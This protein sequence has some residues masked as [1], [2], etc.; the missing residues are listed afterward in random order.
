M[1]GKEMTNHKEQGGVHKE[2]AANNPLAHRVHVEQGWYERPC[3]ELVKGFQDYIQQREQLLGGCFS[4]EEIIRSRLC[5]HA[6]V[7]D[8]IEKD[9]SL[10]L[11]LAWDALAYDRYGAGSFE[12]GSIGLTLQYYYQ[13]THEPAIRLSHPQI[14]IIDALT[15]A[16]GIP[17]QRGQAEIEIPEKLRHYDEYIF[18]KEYQKLVAKA[19][20]KK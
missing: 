16:V 8:K 12:E 10:P 18:S 14:R 2:V 17:H 11:L 3:E 6:L 1:K 5:W 19:K 9:F 13:S 7:D 15:E 20:T 4:P